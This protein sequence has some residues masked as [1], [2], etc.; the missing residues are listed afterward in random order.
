MFTDE[1]NNRTES[2]SQSLERRGSTL[3]AIANASSC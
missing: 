3:V 1:D 2:H